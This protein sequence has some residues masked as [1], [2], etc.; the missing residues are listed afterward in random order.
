MTEVFAENPISVATI[1][2][3]TRY[4][5][6]GDPPEKERRHGVQCY[7]DLIL[8]GL[9]SAI[10]LP[11]VLMLSP[12]L[13]LGAIIQRLYVARMKYHTEPNKQRIA[14]I[15]GGWSG[16]QC[17]AQLH[18]LG[19]HDVKGFEKND[20]WGGTWHPR[21]RYHN[22]QLH[23]AMW[24]TTFKDFPYSSDKD[25]NDGKVSGEEVLNYIDRF[26][27]EKNLMDAYTFN[28]Q[29]I[30]I[31]YSTS[32]LEQ[33]PRSTS[34]PTK[35]EATLVVKDSVTGKIWT[36]GPYDLVIYA[37][38]ASEPHIPDIPGRKDYKGQ[39]LH[40]IDFKQEQY[41]SIVQSGKNVL[42]IGGSKSGCDMALCF[43]RSGYDKFN[44]LYRTPYLFFKYECV[45]HDRSFKNVLRAFTTVVGSLISLLSESLSGY[46]FWANGFA[47]SHGKDP[48]PHNN[49]SK[50]G[51]GILCPK[52]RRDLASISQKRIIQG[53]PHAFT[54]T[55]ICLSDG[56]T[57]DADVVLFATGYESG[58]DKLNLTKNGIK[59]IHKSTTP[60]FNHYFVPDF[61][62]LAN[63][64]N[65]FT[66]YGPLRGVNLAD[67]AVYHL[68]VRRQLTEKQM[69]QSA[70]HHFGSTNTVSGFFFQKHT[71]SIKLFILLHL[72]LLIWGIVN[73]VD[74]SVHYINFFCFANQTAIK[75][76]LPKLKLSNV[77]EE[78]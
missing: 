1:P 57:I 7:V 9:L 55:G 11:C 15:G 59:F 25:I 27:Q 4:S 78:P 28:A 33:P 19:V 10:V 31:K 12:F 2:T 74:L 29:V 68:C 64:A 50:F 22:V 77:S 26:G 30:E 47:V 21:L 52:Q 36:E 20:R 43:Q 71:N 63:A 6:I 51:F 66:T 76:R 48:R 38:I 37:S 35:R 42:L 24:L 34:P 73:I 14:V 67:M 72:D 65:L 18:E 5:E 69:E 13:L 56:M 41:D 45:F 75:I 70:K 60:L 44:W 54:E 58:M 16:L 53:N 39:V 49:W 46:V 32:T 23:S 8:L 61:P 62:V 17:I 3:I 40:S